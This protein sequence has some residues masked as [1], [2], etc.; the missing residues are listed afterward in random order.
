M[1]NSHIFKIKPTVKF[2]R[3]RAK[4]G[5]IIFL[6]IVLSYTS[7]NVSAAG[8]QL[9]EAIM[10]SDF[11]F[12]RSI[13]NVPFIPLGYLTFSQQ[14]SL[15]IEDGCQLEDCELDYQ[16][17]SQ[18]FGLPVWVG[19]KN[20]VIIGETLESDYI[21]LGNDSERINT[22]GVLGA[23]VAQPTEVWQG[24]LFLYAYRGIGDTELARKPKGSVFGGVGRY[25]H[26][27]EFHSYWGI[28]RI[29]EYS[30]ETLYPYI[31]FDWYI[32]KEWSVSALLPWPTISY[33][34][35]VNSIVRL[36][37]LYSGS[38][39]VGDQQGRLQNND[40]QKIDFGLSY[41]HR[42]KGMVWGEIGTGYSGFGKMTI[43]TNSDVDFETDVSGAPFIKLS[44]KIR[45]ES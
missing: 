21:E 9:I 38:A 31:G 10:R 18:G 11:V 41:E 33:S 1:N 22:G 42:L 17:I 13:S 19:Q 32:D 30:E 2:G 7:Q 29:D 16:S 3:L 44:I 40:F 45:P 8:N 28:V 14:N 23:W 12:D 6:L 37:A 35:T 27:P 4:S 39:W 20:M 25:R 36:G 5:L 15:E 26:K 43:R 24:A 34:E